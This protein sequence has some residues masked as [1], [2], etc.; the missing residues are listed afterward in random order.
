MPEAVNEAV[1][2]LAEYWAAVGT[3]RA[4]LRS[5]NVPGVWQGE[6]DNRALARAITDSGAADLLR[7]YRRA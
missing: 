7:N 5:E 6:Y 1:R 2:R 4:G 3:D